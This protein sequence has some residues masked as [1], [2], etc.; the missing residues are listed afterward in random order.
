M[1]ESE[2]TSLDEMRGNMSFGRVPD[3]A[4]YDRRDSAQSSATSHAR[5]PPV[6]NPNRRVT[7]IRASGGRCAGA[8]SGFLAVHCHMRQFCGAWPY[9]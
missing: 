9:R 2:W 7:P 6:P 4:A 3:P 1:A 8:L 5:P